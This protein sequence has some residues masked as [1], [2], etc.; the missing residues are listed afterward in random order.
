MLRAMATVALWTGVCFGV[1]LLSLSA[2][3][4]GELLLGAGCSLATGVVSVLVQRGVG[5]RWGTPSGLARP[6]LVLPVSIIGDTVRALALP[7]RRHRGPAGYRTLEVGGGGVSPAARARRA[8]ATMVTTATPSS[9]VVDADRD[10]GVLTVHGL[11]TGG[12]PLERAL[13]GM[14]PRDHRGKP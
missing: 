3:S 12:S 10:T 1:W 6:L 13:R 9:I 4:L 14:R 11:P 7:M 5:A 8:A 2:L